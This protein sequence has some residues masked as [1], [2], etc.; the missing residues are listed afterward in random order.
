MLRRPPV[1][2]KIGCKTMMLYEL[3]RNHGFPRPVK[4]G[5][6]S[7]WD[8]AEID[9]WLERQAAKRARAESEAAA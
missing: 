4:L 9:R 3:I 8:E 5:R 7:V 1:L 2:E 6:A